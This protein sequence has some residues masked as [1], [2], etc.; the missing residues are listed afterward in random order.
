MTGTEELEHILSLTAGLTIQKKLAYKVIIIIVIN[1]V[2][3]ILIIITI[4]NK[5]NR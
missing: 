3:I 4:N 1:I 2:I 5:D